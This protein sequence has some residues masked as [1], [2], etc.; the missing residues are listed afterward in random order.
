[1]AM[2]I[3]E[4]IAALYEIGTIYT[5]Q[6]KDDDNAI[7]SF[8]RIT[9]EY[10]TS[11]TALPAFY[12]LYRIYVAK[13]QS[14]SFV[15]TGFKDNSDYYKNVILADYPDS[16]FAK[17]ILDPDYITS[18]NQQYAEEK[19]RYEYT[20][21]QFNRRQYSEVLLTCNEVIADEPQNSFL[22][23][24]WLMKALAVGAQKNPDAY[25]NLLREI[26]T[27]FRGTPEADK[28]E[29]LLESLNEVKANMGRA[30]ADDTQASSDPDPSSAGSGAPAGDG[31]VDYSMYTYDAESEHFFALVFAKADGNS[32][33]IKNSISDFNL[34]YFNTDNLR[35]TNSFIDQDNQ[36][37]IVRTFNN[38][39]DAMRYYRG[40]LA[41]DEILK[42]VN[43]GNFDKFVISTKNF[44]VLF[45]NKNLAVYNTFFE[46]KYK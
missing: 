44:T 16:E 26:I 8:L 38:E 21:K 20:Y 14:G 18:K 4:I 32:N 12:Q 34:E 2:A 42:D 41:N 17:L 29:E 11:S 36:I 15:G 35:I 24:Y 39:A 31:G 9:N 40:F 6:L 43:S 19:E 22:A 45:R 10:D 5:E 23:K 28:A 25:E 7:E 1:M 30:T 27:Q 3:N 46:A 37:V 33:S 13:E